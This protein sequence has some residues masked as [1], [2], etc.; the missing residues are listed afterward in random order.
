V[1]TVHFRN[2]K[3]FAAGYELSGD[4]NAVAIALAAEML[5]ETCFGDLTRIHK[6]GLTTVAVSG[7][8]CWD[9]AAGH[10]DQVAFGLVGVDDTLITVFPNGLTE[11]AIGSLAGFACKGVVESYPLRGDVGSLLAFEL[12]IQ[13]RGI[14]A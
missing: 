4:S 14:E 2:A 11:G 7:S 9:A 10:V 13:G 1:S 5:D 12:S 8:G 6:G 3:I